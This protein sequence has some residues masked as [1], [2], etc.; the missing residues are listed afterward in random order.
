MISIFE[1]VQSASRYYILQYWS[2]PYLSL[3]K[4]VKIC[5][6]ETRLGIWWS[7]LIRFQTCILYGTIWCDAVSEVELMKT[8]CDTS[9]DIKLKVWGSSA[10]KLLSHQNS[11]I[12]C[13][14]G[15]QPQ[16]QQTMTKRQGEYN[17]QQHSSITTLLSRASVWLALYWL[18]VYVLIRNYSTET[19]G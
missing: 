10:V 6:N 2:L 3:A 7:T 18:S 13:V 19:Q 1:L 9:C 11:W 4:V 8:I 16:Q 15:A 14:R 12:C 5:I 17:H